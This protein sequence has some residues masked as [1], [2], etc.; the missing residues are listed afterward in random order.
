MPTNTPIATTPPATAT[1]AAAATP[2]SPQSAQ[3]TQ[4]AATTRA[5]AAVAIPKPPQQIDPFVQA[6]QQDIQQ[7]LD[8]RKNR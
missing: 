4:P 1:A 6:V 5:V 3:P 8:S 2:P 7:E